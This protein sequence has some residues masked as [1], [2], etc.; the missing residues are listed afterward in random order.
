VATVLLE[1]TAEGLQ[2]EN[3]AR[4]RGP[5]KKGERARYL[6]RL[7]LRKKERTPLLLSS[8]RSK[9]FGISQRLRLFPQKISMLYDLTGVRPTPPNIQCRVVR[10]RNEY[11][12]NYSKRRARYC[13][14]FSYFSNCSFNS[15]FSSL[16]C[17]ILSS[18][19]TAI[20]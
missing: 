16:S 10:N 14:D 2:A 18:L 19:P 7:L 4:N 6:L 20:P 11:R 17:F 15:S 1:L 8:H 13:Y 3:R 12:L 9:Q 5:H